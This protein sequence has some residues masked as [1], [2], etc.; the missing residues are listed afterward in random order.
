M[1]PEIEF[2]VIVPV[3]HGDPFL[4]AALNSLA[5]LDFPRERFEIIFTGPES[6]QELR[7]A[8][9]SHP[10]SRA[11]DLKYVAVPSSK[12]SVQLN[13]AVSGSR[14]RTLV[15]AD[16][17]CVFFPDWLLNIRSVLERERGVGAVGGRDNTGENEPP[18]NIAVNYVLNSFM[19]TGGLRRQGGP[20]L[21]KYY[22]R[23]WNMAVPR[24]AAL[25]VSVQG[26]EG[27]IHVFN[28]GLDVHEDV[29]LMHRI[30]KAGMR[31]VHAPE[32]MVMHSRDTS[33][34]LFTIRSFKMARTSRN[35]GVHRFPHLC[36][37]AFAVGF[38]LLSAGSVLSEWA[39]MPLALISASYGA[40]LIL[41]ATAAFARSKL[42][43]MFLYVPL[44]LTSIHF[45]RGLGYLFPWPDRSAG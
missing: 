9:T 27:R 23:L 32:I 35:V 3:C 12:K 31:I 40:V 44:L 39:R 30:E 43:S 6:N 7:R 34:R 17:D 41:S 29:E 24:E 2:S 37:A 18:F 11:A 14:G 21:G 45:A 1:S 28:E 20:S 36:L 22:P 33:L 10:A 5:R 38:I 19:G 8:V 13:A 26:P 25:A 15:F 16:D 42:P 4:D